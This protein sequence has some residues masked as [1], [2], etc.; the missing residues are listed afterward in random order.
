MKK[1]FLSAILSGLLIITGSA[2][3]K[4]ITISGKVTSFEES[5]PLEGVSVQVKGSGNNTG[6]QADGIFSLQV[7]SDDKMLFLSLAGYEKK[8]VLITKSKEYDI[9]L[10]RSNGK[11]STIK[12]ENTG[13]L[14]ER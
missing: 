7:S 1:I 2:Q 12:I 14:N 6:T 13:S 5:L 11:F 9:V 4:T 3:S 10:K 8:E